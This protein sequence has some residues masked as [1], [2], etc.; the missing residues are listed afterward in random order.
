M[1]RLPPS[2]LGSAVLPAALPVALAGRWAD[3]GGLWERGIVSPSVC[4]PSRSGS[5]SAPLAPK[6]ALTAHC[7]DCSAAAPSPAP[8]ATRQAA[9]A[10][11]ALAKCACVPSLRRGVGGGRPAGSRERACPFLRDAPYCSR[12][13]GWAAAAPRQTGPLHYDMPNN[14]AVKHSLN[15]DA[16][17]SGHL[18]PV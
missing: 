6:P 10:A 16:E 17:R 18:F 13:H 4:R 1:A 9:H 5:Q 15:Y 8:L 3:G 12:A 2:G 14:T 11:A 7:S